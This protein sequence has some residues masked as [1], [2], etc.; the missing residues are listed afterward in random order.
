MSDPW[1]RLA[2][3][4]RAYLA[5]VAQRDRMNPRDLGYREAVH[6][7]GVTWTAVKRWERTIAK[8]GADPPM[9]MS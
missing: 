3:A 6:H 1:L 8:R 4:R 5:A 7:V 2:D 9:A